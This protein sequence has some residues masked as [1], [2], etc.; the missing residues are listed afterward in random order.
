MSAVINVGPYSL[1]GTWYVNGTATDVGDVTIGIVDANGDT[2]VASG[3]ATTNNG[4]G[5]YTYS[6]ADQTEPNLLTITWTRADT[7]AELT[8]YLE[9]VGSQLFTEAA[10]RTF[11]D[12]AISDTSTYTDALLAS[13]HD[14]VAQFLERETGR[15]W[16]RRY[17]RIVAPGT[18][19]YDLWVADG[20]PRSSTGLTLERPGRNH[21]V[22]QV[23][24]A[25]DGASVS[26]GNIR[27]A[28]DGR[29]T[30]TDAS[31]TKA[32]NTN[33]LNVTV[34]YEYGLPYP[35]DR[36][37][38]VAMMI[39]RQWLVSS[40]VPSGASSFTDPVGTYEFNDSRLPYEA[41]TWIK[42]RRPAALFA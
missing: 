39:A 27:V 29:L 16:I 28:S 41:W 33:P 14:R 32:T 17:C 37:D 30:R 3:T 13:M 7:S 36:V 4:D 40:R 2:V 21:D 5:T 25:N 11:D 20:H 38:E 42:S 24:S 6:L 35:V 1:T 19:N 10:L 23:F 15:S 31:W 12:D 34:E 9:I 18:S 26:T 8:Q 22:I